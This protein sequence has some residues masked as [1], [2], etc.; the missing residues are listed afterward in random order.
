MLPVVET[1]DNF[2]C[3]SCREKQ[4]DISPPEPPSSRAPSADVSRS[5]SP[6]VMEVDKHAASLT[7]N[8]GSD[9]GSPAARGGTPLGF[10]GPQIQLT[11]DIGGQLG[12]FGPSSAP[13]QTTMDYLGRARE[14]LTE[15]GGFQVHQEYR[16]DLLHQLGRMMQE[17]ESNRQSL[18]ELESLREENARLKRENSQLKTSL[19]SRLSREHTFS[20]RR[21]PSA[22]RAFS[23]SANSIDALRPPD[24]S[25]RTWDRIITDVF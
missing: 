1:L 11:P 16:P 3:A 18:Q 2:H 17:L 14:F 25:E 5:A 21:S 12:I 10:R 7:H 19:N 24:A 20:A 4:W 6:N 23:S 15:H 13:F 22:S 9:H 8:T